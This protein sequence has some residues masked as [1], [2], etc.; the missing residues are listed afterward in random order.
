MHSHMLMSHYG[1]HTS[2]GGGL[3][4]YVCVCHVDRST[5]RQVN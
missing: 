3:G 4:V 2:L 5:E 1:M